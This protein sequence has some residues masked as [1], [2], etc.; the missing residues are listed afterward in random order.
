MAIRSATFRT[1]VGA[2]EQLV[3]PGPGD[4]DGEAAA[5]LAGGLVLGPVPGVAVDGAGAGVDPQRTAGRRR[6]AS[7]RPS[8]AVVSVRE[9]QDRVGVAL[10]V[11]AADRAAGQVDQQVGAVQDRGQAAVWSPQRASASGPR[12]MVR[13]RMPGLLVEGAGQVAPDVAG[14]PGHDGGAQRAH[15]VTATGS[16][17]TADG[18]GVL[19]DAQQVVHQGAADRQPREP[20]RATQER[21]QPVHQPTGAT[22]PR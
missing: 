11:A 13:T 5:E 3:L 21:G 22:L 2:C 20:E 15:E 6:R 4:R 12:P 17:V 19:Q 10:G 9:R 8:A 14:R 16:E 18:V 7:A 1:S